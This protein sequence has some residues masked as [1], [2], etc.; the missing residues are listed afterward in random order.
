MSDLAALRTSDYLGSIEV[1]GMF[2]AMSKQ[3]RLQRLKEVREQERLIAHKRCTTYR[4]C[5]DDR[6][7]DKTT[8]KKD[9]IK[10]EKLNKLHELKLE[11]RK[12]HDE[13]GLAHRL[14]RQTSE[15]NAKEMIE[16]TKVALKRAKEEQ[17][18]NR[19][20]H[21][22]QQ[23]E[24]LAAQRKAVRQ[25]ALHQI[26]KEFRQSERE[27]AHAIGETYAV[28][29]QI[30]DA[31]R[32]ALQNLH[33]VPA[34]YTQRRVQQGAASIEQR[35]PVE[36]HA[37]IVRHGVPGAGH[38]DRAAMVRNGAFVEEGAILR[39]TWQC[40]MKEMTTRIRTRVR[41][42]AAQQTVE[43]KKGVQFLDSEL[44]ALEAADKSHGRMGRL[45]S[46]GA[47]QPEV[48]LPR[49]QGA[50]EKVF[51]NKPVRL[52]AQQAVYRTGSHLV[53][54]N[55]DWRTHYADRWS[56]MPEPPSPGQREVGAADRHP[57]WASN[58]SPGSQRAQYGGGYDASP[59]Y[60]DGLSTGGRVSSHSST[61]SSVAPYQE[62]D[63]VRSPSSR[64]SHEDSYLE[65]DA[66]VSRAPPKFTTKVEP[67]SPESVAAPYPGTP[68]P[69]GQMRPQQQQ[70]FQQRA[71]SGLQVRMP[72]VRAPAAGL[73]SSPGSRSQQSAS[74]ASTAST[75]SSAPK[76]TSSIPVVIRHPM[77]VI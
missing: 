53:E 46:A 19:L 17:Q 68:E 14:A 35:F 29:Q 18:R 67:G 51:L 28:R 21:Q 32:A 24:L 31:Q 56:D 5:I 20:A 26:K 49:L 66:A 44:Q 11:A 57:Q 27:D 62:D 52:E 74:L 13:S 39:K 36:V 69:L 40:V 1:Q 63:D 6:K 3:L 42:K 64:R 77:V 76:V 65:A 58:A 48:E 37:R 73:D 2:V 45:N 71:L 55:L 9:Q 10:S 75:D 47:V 25:Q 15:T 54:A 72:Q 30:L 8:A 23:E 22:V 70:L 43:R 59:G 16:N 34:V 38:G 33:S 4:Q 7:Y 41:A 60:N 50:F 12:A 61:S